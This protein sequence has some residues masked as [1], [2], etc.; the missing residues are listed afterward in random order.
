MKNNMTFA[1]LILACFFLSACSHELPE[2]TPSYTEMSLGEFPAS[3]D[4]ANNIPVERYDEITIPK[5]VSTDNRKD[6]Q[7]I[8]KALKE[9]FRLGLQAVATP[10]FNANGTSKMVLKGTYRCISGQYSPPADPQMLIDLT[11]TY[12]FTLEE[13]AHAG[14]RF[15]VR[16][17]GSQ[18]QSCN[19]DLPVMLFKKVS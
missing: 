16:I 13:A 14:D 19:K 5:A 9:P 17:Q 4:L 6:G 15:F 12:A 8:R 1:S 18:N 3:R 10:V 11:R 7:V 2:N